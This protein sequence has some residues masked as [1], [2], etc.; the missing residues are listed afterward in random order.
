MKKS[1]KQMYIHQSKRAEEKKEEQQRRRD[2]S[3]FLLF[4]FFFLFRSLSPAAL[5]PCFSS[6]SFLQLTCL[7][8]KRVTTACSGFTASSRP[9]SSGD[10]RGDGPSVLSLLSWFLFSP[11]LDFFPGSTR[12][13]WERREKGLSVVMGEGRRRFRSGWLVL[14]GRWR[15]GR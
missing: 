9:S 1:G 6:R 2:C 14:R 12:F 7:R 10:A 4:S 11:W 13:G 5:Y 15:T 8:G 3:L